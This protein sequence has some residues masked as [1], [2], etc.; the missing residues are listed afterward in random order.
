MKLLLLLLLKRFL[1]LSLSLLNS[2][3]KKESKKCLHIPWT[4]V[5][6][7]VLMELVLV[8]AAMTEGRE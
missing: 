2:T 3:G 8:V 6:M 5:R 1:S 7:L 4:E